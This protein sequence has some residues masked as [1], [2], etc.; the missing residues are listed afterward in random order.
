TTPAVSKRLAQME[1]RLG[2]SLVTRTTRR[3][4]LTPEGELYLLRARRI[5]AEI[6][7]MEQSLAGSRA[8][9]R[10]LSRLNATPGFRRPYVPP[11]LSRDLLARPEIDV[12]LPLSVDPPAFSDDAFDVG[13]RFGGPPEAR[14]IARRLTAP[15][16]LL[17]ASQA[18][19]AK[20]GSPCTPADLSR[21]NCIG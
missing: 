10:G 19:L 1:A 16:R 18:D 14:V 4:H 5:L 12:Q 3:M 11:A 15:R 17:C 9:P 13:I 2:V 6:D 20:H 21:H 8:A 7:D